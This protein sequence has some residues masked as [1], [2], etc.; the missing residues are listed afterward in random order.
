[1]W[2]DDADVGVGWVVC[3]RTQTMASVALTSLIRLRTRGT[4]DGHGQSAAF[5]VQTLG[6]LLGWE[7]D[8]ELQLV[9]LLFRA[10]YY[11]L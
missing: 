5:C 8:S 3:L 6:D 10:T 11:L 7:S 9:S 1:M 2:A 4:E